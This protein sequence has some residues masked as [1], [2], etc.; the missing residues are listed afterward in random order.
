MNHNSSKLSGEEGVESVKKEKFGAITTSHGL[1]PGYT[2]DHVIGLESM[3]DRRKTN[4]SSMVGTGIDDHLDKEEDIRVSAP[5]EIELSTIM[6]DV[7]VGQVSL[8]FEASIKVTPPEEDEYP[9]HDVEEPLSPSPRDS[10][11]SDL[12]QSDL[13]KANETFNLK[14]I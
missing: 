13:T 3:W 4:M 14:I 1:D 12:Q 5:V 6:R 8:E 11:P 10:E 2:E 9:C 7:D